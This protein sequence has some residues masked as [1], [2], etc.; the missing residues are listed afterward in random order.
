MNSADK[1]INS[2]FLKGFHLLSNYYLGKRLSYMPYKL[3]RYLSCRLLAI[4]FMMFTGSC[5][6]AADMESRIGHQNL[7]SSVWDNSRWAL[8]LSSRFTLD[9]N[10]DHLS[11]QHVIG[12]D[13]HKVFTGKH[14][15]IATLVFQ[16]YWVRLNAVNNPAYFFD[17]GDDSEVTW[18]IANI[19]FTGLSRSALNFRVGHF[20]V[21]FGLEKNIDTNGTLRQYSF[22]DRG[23][24]AD[25]GVSVNGVL[26]QFDYEVA[27]TRG[28]GNN[29]SGRDNPHVFAGRIGTPSMGNTVVGFSWFNGKV[30]AAE[31]AIARKRLGI[32]LVHYYR[33]WEVLLEVSGGNNSGFDR[34]SAIA[35]LSWRNPMES[36]HTYLQLRHAKQEHSDTWQA[37]SSVSLGVQWEINRYVNVSTEWFK[38][39]DAIVGQEKASKLTAQLRVRI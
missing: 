25:W 2:H 30:L 5:A 6:V 36:L 1:Y 31:G 19:N 29:I 17:G 39:L 24:K 21:P 34:A 22:S 13:F 32:D 16:P 8:D 4:F 10:N 35:E 11:S 33:Q 28:S 12:F 7:T 37:L 18:R 20:E 26:A 9:K 3:V 27:L 23:V 38:E 14:G 15:D